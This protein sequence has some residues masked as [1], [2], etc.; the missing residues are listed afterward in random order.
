MGKEE[1][2]ML[3]PWV[4]TLR[5]TLEALHSGRP[6]RETVGV[7]GQRLWDFGLDLWRLRTMAIQVERLCDCMAKGLDFGVGLWRFHT[8]RGQTLQFL[9]FVGNFQPISLDSQQSLAIQSH[10]LSTWTAIV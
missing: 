3:L 7:H 1:S 5:L 4:W 10:S 8:L 6:C 2:G 9:Y